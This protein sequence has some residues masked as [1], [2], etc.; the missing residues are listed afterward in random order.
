M[1]G[2]LIYTRNPMG[3]DVLM[4]FPPG[5]QATQMRLPQ[6]CK[7]LED[8]LKKLGDWTATLFETEVSKQSLTACY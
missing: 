1:D 2:R 8:S 5:G 7:R 4:C 3:I 6:A